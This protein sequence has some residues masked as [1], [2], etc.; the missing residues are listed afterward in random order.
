METELESIG[1][2]LSCYAVSFIFF[3]VTSIIHPVALHLKSPEDEGCVNSLRKTG[4]GF[5]LTEAWKNYQ[6]IFLNI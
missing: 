3:K 6:A 5:A 2:N 1:G 4:I